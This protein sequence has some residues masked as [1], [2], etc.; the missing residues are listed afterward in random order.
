MRGG[1]ATIRSFAK[2][3]GKPLHTEHDVV[4]GLRTVLGTTREVEVVDY[5]HGSDHRLV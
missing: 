4:L 2:I 1:V 5:C 3:V